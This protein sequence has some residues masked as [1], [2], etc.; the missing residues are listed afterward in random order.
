[1]P[2]TYS[3]IGKSV[4]SERSYGMLRFLI[5]TSASSRSLLT[6]Y[7]SVRTAMWD[8]FKLYAM[9][10]P[11]ILAHWQFKKVLFRNKKLERAVVL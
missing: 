5:H 2:T 7:K 6:D 11:R 1:M 8:L 9:I 4:D 3:D 10:D